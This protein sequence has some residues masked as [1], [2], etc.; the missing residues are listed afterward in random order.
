M[1]KGFHST[2]RQQLVYRPKEIIWLRVGGVRGLVRMFSC[3]EL[4]MSDLLLGRLY[5]RHEFPA[6]VVAALPVLVIRTM[7]SFPDQRQPSPVVSDEDRRERLV[8][9]AAP[10][11]L[12]G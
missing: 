3:E 5:S 12:G 7:L 4:M 9:Q 2:E 10:S 11:W 6:S 8:S 1:Q